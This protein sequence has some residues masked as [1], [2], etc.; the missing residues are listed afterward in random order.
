MIDAI[1]LLP[2]PFCGEQ[3][4]ISKNNW[5]TAIDC[6]NDDCPAAVSVAS[7]AGQNAAERWNTRAPIPATADRGPNI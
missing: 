2:C 6:I 4:Q 1:E 7:D 5:A 3:P